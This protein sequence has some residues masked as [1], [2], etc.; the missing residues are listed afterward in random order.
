M[1]S[2][3]ANGPIRVFRTLGGTSDI[4]N[5]ASSTG[6]LASTTYVTVNGIGNFGIGTSTP[7]ARLSVEGSSALGNSATSGYF[8][9]TTST[10]SVFPYASSTAQ[11]ISGTLYLDNLNGPLQANNGVVSA[12]TSI[13][14]VYGGTGLTS[15]TPGDLLYASGATTLAGT[16]TANLK[17]SLALNNVENT[18]LSTWAG[19]SN[20]TTLGT[21]TS[22]TWNGNTIGVAHYKQTMV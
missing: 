11:T 3:P 1:V 12:T 15:Y 6:G 10:A 19:S 20:I 8:I 4:F 22:G 2:A 13:G 18:A 17:A 21:I 7:Y 14:V 5:I 16:S 9:A